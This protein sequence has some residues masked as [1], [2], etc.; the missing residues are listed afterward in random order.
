VFQQGVN[1]QVDML[2]VVDD[3]E[4][5][6]PWAET[7]RAGWP[8]IA[9]ALEQLPQ[10]TPDLHVGFVRA[11]RCASPARAAACGISAPDPFL[12]HERCGALANFA[13]SFVDTFACLA[14]L[15]P[16]TCAGAGAQPFQALRD[17]LAQPPRAGWEEFLRPDALLH[18]V[19]IAGRDDPSGAGVAEL[20]AFVR[21]RKADPPSQVLLSVLVP[22][23]CA[24]GEPTPR[25]IELA[26]AF[27]ANAAVGR[28]CDNPT[29][30]VVQRLAWQ[31]SVL[32]EPPC[33]G[34][35]LDVDP[36]APG[37]QAE[38]TFEDT[39]SPFDGV[40]VTT[41]LPAC[42]AAAPPC[43][44]LTD[45]PERGC[46]IVEI[47]RGAAFCPGRVTYTKIEC[48]SAKD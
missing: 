4:A 28:L 32:I 12:R 26:Q 44:R 13:G 35:V 21:A 9:R 18:I 29:N 6:A 33:I 45:A 25:L 16:P 17:T 27:G 39:V 43:W 31:I 7:L 19:I 11:S 41:L 5:A 23:D 40:L 15:G 3:T 2:F 22:G 37:L 24:P 30:A 46:A 38:C 1:R 14:E 36:A 48:L 8:A 20:A 47:D 10:G 42:D 34:P